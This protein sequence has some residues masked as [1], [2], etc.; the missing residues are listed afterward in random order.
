M[1]YYILVF[2]KEHVPK[3]DSFANVS[4]TQPGRLSAR[5]PV[6]DHRLSTWF[7]FQYFQVRGISKWFVF[8]YVQVQN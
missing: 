2:F 1:I 4:V 3:L 7:V 6:V 8:Q 5:P